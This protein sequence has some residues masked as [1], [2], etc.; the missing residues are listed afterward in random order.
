MNRSLL[1]MLALATCLSGSGVV[2]AED[3]WLDELDLSGMTCG[4][5][6]PQ[7]K[8]SI[9][10]NPIKINGKTYAHGVGLHAVSRVVF[11]LD[12]KVTRF[13]AVVGVDDE[14]NPTSSVNYTVVA[15]GKTLF[16][17]DMMK[18]KESKNFWNITVMEENL[19]LWP[20]MWDYLTRWSG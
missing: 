13:Q 4:Y 8:K 12:G 1:K 17:S 14:G 5:L 2:Q 15:D 19:L 6:K 10:G 16:S 9:D 18:L 3:V 7:L 11:Q 20:T